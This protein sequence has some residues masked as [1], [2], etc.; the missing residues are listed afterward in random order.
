L[1]QETRRTPEAAHPVVLEGSPPWAQV[2]V[3]GRV[4]S[5]G[6]RLPL[7]AGPHFVIAQG[8]GFAPLAAV[9]V[10]DAEHLVVR[11]SPLEGEARRAAIRAAPGALAGHAGTAEALTD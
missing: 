5:P 11:L 4:A 7:A 3:D 10:A 6:D 2:S 1:W 9:L 8:A